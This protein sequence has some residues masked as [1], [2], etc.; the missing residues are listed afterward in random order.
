MKEHG[1]EIIE[2]W[3]VGAGQ[4][5]SSPMIIRLRS[6]LDSAKGKKLFP[7]MMCMSWSFQ[8][9]NQVGMPSKA[10][11][12]ELSEFEDRLTESF[13]SDLQSVLTIAITKSGLREWYFYTNNID[14]FMNRLGSVPH[15]NENPIE[16]YFNND[17][18][19]KYYEDMRSICEKQ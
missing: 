17:E 15:N 19:W 18:N 5:P 7:H 13:E 3:S 6:K 8:N 4:D 14:E 16:I 2:D 1:F 10:E 9:P 11:S 12:D